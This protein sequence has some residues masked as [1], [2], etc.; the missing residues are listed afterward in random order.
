MSRKIKKKLGKINANK[1]TNF[2]CRAFVPSGKRCRQDRLLANVQDTTS[3]TVPFLE[4]AW[5]LDWGAVNFSCSSERQ[6]FSNFKLSAL[7]QPE[8]EITL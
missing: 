7:C 2:R 3:G 4:V 1:V 6:L 8:H 5:L